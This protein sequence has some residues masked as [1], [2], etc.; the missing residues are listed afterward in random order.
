MLLRN[1]YFGYGDT[2][3]LRGTAMGTSCCPAYANLNLACL[4]ADSIEPLPGSYVRYRHI[5]SNVQGIRT[6]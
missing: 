4:E 3:Y 6:A 5:L 2:V 1:D